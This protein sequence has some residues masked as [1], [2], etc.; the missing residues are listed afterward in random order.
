MS[1]EHVVSTGD[2]I[3][4]IALQYG[5]FADTLWNHS[6][7]AAL[8]DLRKD[9]NVLLPGDIVFIPDLDLEEQDAATEQHH[10]FRR[11]GVPARLR[12]KFMRPKKPEEP[13]QDSGGGSGEYDPSEYEE[14]PRQNAE[15]FE[16]IAS[17]PFVLEIDGVRTEGRSDGEGMVDVPIPPNAARG[18]IKF[19]VGTDDEIEFELSLGE[20]APAD[21]VIGARMRLHNLG[22]R[23]IATGDELDPPMI[24][25]LKRFQ[26]DQELT[27][28]GECDSATQDKLKE[29]HGS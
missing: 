27:V 21:T 26:T 25:A 8:K 2:C 28:N 17:A 22:Y 5:F 15:E 10:R 7:N 13:A 11:K 6:Q 3:D 29:I 9:Q 16:V 14:V 12:M 4:S 18:K 23:C 19:D 1:T 24:D 20:L